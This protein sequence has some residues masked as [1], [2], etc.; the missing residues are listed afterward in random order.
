MPRDTLVGIIEPMLRSAFVH[1]SRAGFSLSWIRH[2]TID[3]QCLENPP[4]PEGRNLD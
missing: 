2:W 4:A 3:P 1:S